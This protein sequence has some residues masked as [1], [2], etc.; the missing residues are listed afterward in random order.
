MHAHTT[1]TRVEKRQITPPLA[2]K[3]QTGGITKAIFEASSVALRTHHT[4]HDNLV[5][6]FI[7]YCGLIFII[8]S[9]RKLTVSLC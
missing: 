6:S 5:E 2:L 7:K 4:A 9:L 8:P 1:H 3:R